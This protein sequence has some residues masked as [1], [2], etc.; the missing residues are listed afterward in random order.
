[1]KLG[2][3]HSARS[4][5][6][7]LPQRSD[8]VTVILANGETLPARVVELRQDTLLVAIMVP[9]QPLS[10]SQLDGLVLE[11]VGPR[12]R[13]RLGG[14]AAVQ[15]PCEPDVVRIDRLRPL[16]VLQEREWYRLEANCPVLVYLGGDQMPIQSYTADISGGGFLLAGP[17][18]LGVGDEFKFQLTLVAGQLVIAGTG[19][20]MRLDAEG[21]RAVAFSTI[22]DFDQR[23]LVRFL[24]DYQRTERHRQV[25]R[26]G[27]YGS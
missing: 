12:G 3:G 14:E 18:L 25:E 17:D 23:R 11:F 9:I 21:R 27:N 13:I 7:A 20:V 6:V 19:T 4:K 15:D 5:P 8:T 10:A 26:N 16:E 1:M 2:R 24:F 22:S